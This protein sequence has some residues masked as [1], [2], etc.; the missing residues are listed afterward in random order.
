MFSGLAEFY[1]AH[2]DICILPWY[3]PC[4][5]S[6]CPVLQTVVGCPQVSRAEQLLDLG[7]CVCEQ[8][9]WGYYIFSRMKEHILLRERHL[10]PP[11]AFA[12]LKA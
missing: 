3:P 6:L 9:V 7:V 11:G 10:G 8:G 1:P 5:L 2:V 4:A 12:A